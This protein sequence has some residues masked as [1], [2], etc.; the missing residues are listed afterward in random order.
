MRRPLARAIAGLGTAALI[1]GSAWAAEPAQAS[2]PGGRWQVRAEGMA[3]AVF[4]RGVRVKT[5]A[6][7]RRSGQQPSTVAEFHAVPQ[8]RSFVIA[9][10]SLAELWEL[11]IDPEAEPLFDGLVHDYRLKEGLAEPGFLGVRRTPLA[12]PLGDLKIDDSGAY[13]LGRE[14]GDGGA[15]RLVQLDVRRAIARFAAPK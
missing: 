8:R 2:S 5:I 13:V 3:V 6:T 7:S 1:L 12:Q 9:F 11:S 10:D 14:K 15:L 4:D